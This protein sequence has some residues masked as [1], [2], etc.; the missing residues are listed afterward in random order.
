MIVNVLVLYQECLWAFCAK[1][2]CTQNGMYF[3]TV[4]LILHGALHAFSL[5]HSG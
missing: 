3:C 1:Y 2:I 5:A 4:V